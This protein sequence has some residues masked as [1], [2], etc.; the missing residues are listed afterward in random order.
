M[1]SAGH[2][3]NSRPSARGDGGAFRHDDWAGAISIHA[4]PRGATQEAIDAIMRYMISIHA[5]PRGAT[6][7]SFASSISSQI[8]QFTPLRE[9]RL[10]SLSSLRISPPI[11]I[12]APPRGATSFPR[13]DNTSHSF[14]FTPLREGRRLPRRLLPT[15]RLHFNSRPSARGDALLASEYRL[16]RISIHAPPRGATV[17]LRSADMLGLISIHAPPRGATR[18]KSVTFSPHLLFQFTPLREGRLTQLCDTWTESDFNSRPSARGDG[19]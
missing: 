16:C 10:A 11:S 9:G 14:Q 17:L 15:C 2:H 8:F 12:H 18:S 7:S 6:I 5:P 19:R 13:K 1:S 4:P 3:F